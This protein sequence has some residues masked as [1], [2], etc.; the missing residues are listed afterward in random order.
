MNI[1]LSIAVILLLIISLINTEH[2]CPGYGYVAEPVNCS[3]TCSQTNDQC[4]IGR[5]CCHRI[6]EPCGFH[7]IISKDNK[8]KLG[9]CPTRVTGKLSWLLCDAVLC[10]VDDDCQGTEKCC[11]NVCGSKICLKPQ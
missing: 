2:I 10:D 5:K 9:E 7:C 6:E 3:S 8:K 4:P 1:S 11:T